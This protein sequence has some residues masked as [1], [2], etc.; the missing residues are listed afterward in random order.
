MPRTVLIVDDSKLARMV[1]SKT[2]AKIHPDWACV[3]A[4]DATQAMAALQ[5]QDVDISLIDLN[6]PGDGGLVLAA[7]LRRKRPNMPI[8]V[9]TAN[10]QEEIVARVRELGATFVPK[11]LTEEALSAFLTGANLRLRKVAQ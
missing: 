11:P 1:A 10:I 7:D 6:M 8:A 4:G 5:A 9:V 2:L 3:E